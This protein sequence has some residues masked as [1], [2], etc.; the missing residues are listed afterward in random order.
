MSHDTPKCR[1]CL[2][3]MEPDTGWASATVL[4]FYFV[5]GSCQSQTPHGTSRESALYLANHPAPVAVPT[6]TPPDPS[7]EVVKL[8]DAYTSMLVSYT[9]ATAPRGTEPPLNPYHKRVIAARAA[10]MAEFSRLSKAQTQEQVPVKILALASQ[11]IHFPGL[12]PAAV[13]RANEIIEICVNPPSAKPQAQA[14]E[15]LDL[16]K[17]RVFME[18][19]ACRKGAPVVSE[20]DVIDAADCWADEIDRLTQIDT[21]KGTETPARPNVHD[22]L[23]K[24]SAEGAGD[25]EG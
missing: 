20:S 15:A 10:L 16:G 19:V 11:L 18:V 21:P 24:L 13:A 7:P 3:A 6:P 9:L 23:S 5:C 8:V 1:Y 14:P 25:G 22:M 2:G 17:L 12:H 4:K